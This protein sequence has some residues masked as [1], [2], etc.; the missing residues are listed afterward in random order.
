[1]VIS[2]SGLVSGEPPFVV[3]NELVFVSA[4]LKC[5]D[6]HKF[7]SL[8]SHGVPFPPLVET[9]NQEYLVSSEAPF[10]YVSGKICLRLLLHI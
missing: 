6:Q 7:V 4:S 8:F 9:S 3:Y 2:D 1:M 5:F 10:E